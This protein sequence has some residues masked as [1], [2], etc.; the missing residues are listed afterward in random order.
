MPSRYASNGFPLFSLFNRERGC[1]CPSYKRWEHLRGT[2]HKSF[3]REVAAKISKGHCLQIF[4]ICSDGRHL[5]SL[6]QISC[7]G[8][9]QDCSWS[10]NQK[11]QWKQGFIKSE[12]FFIF[13]HTHM[14]IR[15]SLDE[16]PRPFLCMWVFL[17]QFCII[18]FCLN[19]TYNV[20]VRIS[21]VG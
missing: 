18:F 10:V 9:T 3:T 6:S 20:I 15:L 4:Y 11:S 21:S 17:L 7:N 12:S 16:G 14:F 19:H 13:K 5:S 8:F 2:G 1:W